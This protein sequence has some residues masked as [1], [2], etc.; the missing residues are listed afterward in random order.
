MSKNSNCHNHVDYSEDKIFG[1]FQTGYH[2]IFNFFY[3]NI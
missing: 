3:F 2:V 1:T